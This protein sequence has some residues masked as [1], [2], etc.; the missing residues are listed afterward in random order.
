MATNGQ[1]PDITATV[2]HHS[3]PEEI[4]VPPISDVAAI[5]RIAAV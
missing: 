4:H 1:D 3:A 5:S 2:G